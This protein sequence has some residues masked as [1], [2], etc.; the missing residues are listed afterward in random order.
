LSGSPLSRAVGGRRGAIDG[1]L[2]PVTFVAVNA[3]ARLW[4]SPHHALLLAGLAAG[5]IGLGLVGLRLARKQTLKQSLRGLT[6]VLVALLFTAWSGEARDFFRPGIIVD[7]AYSVTFA[8]STLIGW[9]LVGVI[10]GALY[11]RGREWRRDD[12]LRRLMIVA[13]LGWSIVYAVRAL[14]QTSFYRADQPE[15]LALSKLVLGWPVTVVALVLTL[16]AVRRVGGEQ[17]LRVSSV[18]T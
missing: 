16:A 8:V 4:T 2:P 15:M 5:G 11:H 3:V 14:V 17:A 13:T 7:A 9:P 18:R 1:G 6:G 12:R 10:Y